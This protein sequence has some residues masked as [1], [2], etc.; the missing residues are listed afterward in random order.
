M[1]DALLVRRLQRIGDLFRDQQCVVEWDGSTRDPL[2]EILTFD[3]F[4]H[5][6]LDAVAVFQS[7]DGGDVRMVQ[8]GEDLGFALKS[9]EPVVVSGE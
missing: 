1:D 7:I 4:H 6:G 8:G 9:R 5:E 2:R 3:E